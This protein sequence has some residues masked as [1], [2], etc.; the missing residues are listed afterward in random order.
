MSAHIWD[1]LLLA[2]SG[3]ALLYAGLGA[4]LG[5]FVGV[6]PGLGPVATIALLLPVSFQ[7][8]PSGALILL[9]GIYYGAQYGSS[10]TAILINVPGEASGTV[11]AIEG[12]RLARTGRATEALAVAALSSLMAGLIAAL[13][14][15]VATPPLAAFALAIGPAETAAILLGGAILAVLISS[16]GTARAVMMLGLGGLIG[17]I[18]TA[19]GD[20]QPRFSFGLRELR[21]G[22]GF[23][24]LVVGLFGFSE[25]IALMTR[26]PEEQ[27]AVPRRW[28][29]GYAAIRGWEA[30]ALRGS[31]IGSLVGLLPGATTLMASF[32]AYSAEKRLKRGGALAGVAAPEAAN[33]AAAQTS[34][35]MLFG[36][37]LPA[38]AATAVLVGAMMLNG[39]PPGPALFSH[40]PSLFWTFV[41]SLVVANFMLVVL[42]LPLVGIWAR[43]VLVPPAI[44]APAIIVAAALGILASGGAPF[45]VLALMVFG[46]FG[47]AC[48]R[49]GFPLMPMLMGY[50]IAPPFED[51][52]RRAIT[53]ARGDWTILLA[54]PFLMTALALAMLVAVVKYRAG[55]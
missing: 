39:L 21:D 25:L 7:M 50:V 13:I 37:G 10:T 34:F 24:P 18:G 38:N 49:N 4:L 40:S 20:G 22:I 43:L 1:G 5:T 33:N 52:L 11:T 51:H 9:A 41:G 32:L 35:V 55:S 16:E 42:N 26:R 8:S 6:L 23:T 29:P 17:L 48:R 54:N 45:D 30:P 12:H 36:L 31:V 2:L 15:A 44:L 19:G 53:H 46:L 47:H 14:L 3:E 28:W 27:P